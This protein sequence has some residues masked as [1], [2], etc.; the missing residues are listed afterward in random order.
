MKLAAFCQQPILS[1][2]NTLRSARLC[3][4]IANLQDAF[5]R[6]AHEIHAR[7]GR[8]RAKKIVPQPL[9]ILLRI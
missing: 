8:E 6:A 2:L 9:K 7:P 1:A 5:G 3:S 4:A